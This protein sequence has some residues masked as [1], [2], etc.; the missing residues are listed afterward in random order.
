[1]KEQHVSCQP[2]ITVCSFLASHIS[3]P[4]RLL[5]IRQCIRSI[6][7]QVLL[8]SRLLIS[9][10]SADADLAARTKRLLMVE[11]R[12]L[13]CQCFEQEHCTSQFGHYKFLASQCGRA[14]STWI[15]FSDDVN[16]VCTQ[17]THVQ[18]PTGVCL[19]MHPAAPALAHGRTIFGIR[20]G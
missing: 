9:W 5:T 13:P 7:S 14:D 6:R 2:P 16:H 11:T 17:T 8:P 15:L 4:D 12:G 3:T 18:N 19:I 20:T 1:M 10:S